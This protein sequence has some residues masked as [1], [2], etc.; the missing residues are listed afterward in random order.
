MTLGQLEEEST[1]IDLQSA[2]NGFNMEAFNL[3]HETCNIY[4]G[5]LNQEGVHTQ[6]LKLLEEYLTP[7]TQSQFNYYVSGERKFISQGWI[8]PMEES[9]RRACEEIGILETQ[10]RVREAEL[11]SFLQIQGFLTANIEAGNYQAKAYLQSPAENYDSPYSFVSQYEIVPITV[12]D[13]SDT[14]TSEYIIRATNHRVIGLPFMEHSRVR[15]IWMQDYGLTGAAEPETPTVILG[16][17]LFSAINSASFDDMLQEYY[18]G[19]YPID[20]FKAQDKL[21][22]QE[23]QNFN[24]EVISLAEEIMHNATNFI[25]GDRNDLIESFKLFLIKAKIHFDRDAAVREW[26]EEVVRQVEST[27]QLAQTEDISSPNDATTQFELLRNQMLN[28]T[29]QI[30]GTCGTIGDSSIS[31]GQ[32]TKALMHSNFEIFTKSAERPDETECPR[33]HVI[34]YVKNGNVA[35]YHKECPACGKDIQ[36]K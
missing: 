18:I 12:L 36:C 13:E 34:F 26:G 30:N 3:I 4:E 16:N 29:I 15:Q 20:S 28:L 8:Q 19:Y 17:P 27:I 35:T 2:E 9:Y 5:K 1:Q 32:V 22:F 10:K 14:A 21:I 33:C 11:D 24:P 25:T 7:L 6:L 31:I 23:L